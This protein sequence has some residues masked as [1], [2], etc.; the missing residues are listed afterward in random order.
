MD[1]RHIREMDEIEA[2]QIALRESIEAT[3]DLARQ[4]DALLQRHREMVEAGQS[5][6]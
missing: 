3:K 4:A 6:H 1:E 2:T 5:N